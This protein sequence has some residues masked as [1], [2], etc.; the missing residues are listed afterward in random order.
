[1]PGGEPSTSRIAGFFVGVAMLAF[2]TVA[3]TFVILG[4]ERLANLI[5]PPFWPYY[6][7]AAAGLVLLWSCFPSRAPTRRLPVR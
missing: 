7:I 3:L 1:M 2:G 6:A 5:F 4:G